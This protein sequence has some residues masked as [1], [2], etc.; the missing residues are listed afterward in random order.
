MTLRIVRQ[1]GSTNDDLALAV[2]QPP[3]PDQWPTGE[4]DTL[5]ARE[6]TA[7]R[8]RMGREW[9]TSGV[10]ALTFSAVF[11]PAWDRINWGWIPLVAGAVIARELD[12]RLKWP[13]DLVR[14][15][16]AGFA[17]EGWD[18]WRK[19]GGILT[20]TV[21]VAD[22]ERVVIGVGLNLDLS[23]QLDP[24][25]FHAGALG[26]D[27]DEEARVELV[28]RLVAGLAT[29]LVRPAPHTHL[30]A[31]M[32]QTLGENVVV[33]RGTS[34]PELIGRAVDL[35]AHGSL[36]IDTGDEIVWISSGDVLFIR[37]NTSRG[38]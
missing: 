32:T 2:A 30:V 21:P 37:S 34:A 3:S 6:Q 27:L 20:Q 31:E 7:G 16:P 1:T 14:L 24:P 35:D 22:G 19:V 12:V 17:L 26:L 8:G 10:D 25:A 23:A 15:D 18:Q 13:N 33:N 4:G 5:W 29:E 9:D 38:D 11:T 28:E 36:G